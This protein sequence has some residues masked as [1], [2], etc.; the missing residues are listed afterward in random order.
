M[1]KSYK[2]FKENWPQRLELGTI[3]KVLMALGLVV[4]LVT[5][6]RTAMVYPSL[7]AEIP[8]HY[9][10]SGNVTSY[11]DKFTLI[12]LVGVDIFCWL[13]MVVCNFFPQ[14]INV[15][16]F[17]LR[18]EPEEIIRGTR[19]YLNATILLVAGMF[20]YIQEATIRVATGAAMGI[21]M[22]I[23]VFTALIFISMAIYFIWMA[24]G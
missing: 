24:K 16:I 15:P 12:I 1:V 3:D 6:A 11:D 10:A 23:W 19:V 5:A 4:I 2:A 7:P 17:L 20:F 14:A 21:G 18:R 13:M 22:G 9:D 8:N